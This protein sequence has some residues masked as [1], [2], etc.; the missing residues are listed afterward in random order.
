MSELE[1]GDRLARHPR[2][3]THLRQG[4]ERRTTGALADAYTSSP[5]FATPNGTQV[6]LTAADAEGLEAVLLR[7]VLCRSLR[8]RE[9]FL[10]SRTATNV[11]VWTCGGYS[12]F[13][14][15]GQGGLAQPDSGF[16]VGRHRASRRVSP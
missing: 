4:Q 15:S 13:P 16:R 8:L 2:S 9:L 11:L 6:G 1:E 3:P 14:S 10:F 5:Q 12:S 7:L